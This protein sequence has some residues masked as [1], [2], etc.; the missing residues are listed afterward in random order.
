MNI[1]LWSRLGGYIVGNNLA[2]CCL[3]YLTHS[4]FSWCWLWER[5]KSGNCLR[6]WR[7]V[8][9]TQLIFELN[10]FKQ[11]LSKDHL[12]TV[13]DIT[14]H[15]RSKSSLYQTER[16][17]KKKSHNSRWDFSEAWNRRSGLCIHPLDLTKLT[18]DRQVP[19][20]QKYFSRGRYWGILLDHFKSSPR[21]QHLILWKVF[22]GFFA[23]PLNPLCFRPWLTTRTFMRSWR[24]GKR[25][26]LG[27]VCA[28]L[29]ERFPLDTRL[30]EVVYQNA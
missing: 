18:R 13:G 4:P 28:C 3:H 2:V 6:T 24:A 22:L 27:C 30:C 8:L 1:F 29:C 7:T 23:E 20:I 10:H 21:A 5:K 26:A 9:R 15:E 16:G 25:A 17:E 14:C 11:K 19:R 12:L